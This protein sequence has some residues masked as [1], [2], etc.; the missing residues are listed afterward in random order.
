MSTLVASAPP[1]PALTD[2]QRDFVRAV[3]DFCER[4]CSGERLRE[5]TDGYE[6]FHSPELARRMAALGW[7]GLTI[8]EEYGGAGASVSDA[9][10]FLEEIGRAQ[11]PVRGCA[12]ALIVA[13]GIRRDGSESQKE[14]LLNRVAA[15]GQLSGAVSEPEAGSDVAALRTAARRDGDA[16][17][18]N[19]TKTWCSFAHHAS[20]V[21]VLCRTREGSTGHEGLSSIVVPADAPGLA[22]SPISTLGGHDVNELHFADC[23]VPADAL[24]GTEGEGWTQVMAGFN[25]E[26]VLLGALALGLAQRAFDD[27]LA[28]VKERRQFG[29]PVG[30]FQSMQHRFA[31]LATALE[32]ARL[33]VRQVARLVDEQPDRLLPREASMVK[34]A[35]TELAK[36]CALEGVQAMGACGYATEYPMERHLRT[37]VA[38]TIFG[39]TSEIQKNTIA[40][41]L[42]L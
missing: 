9:A 31:D 32:Q 42:G 29:R 21:M 35:T 15:G 13:E 19:G 23:T 38:T 37:A 20:H 12:V 11:A 10:L 6:D 8:P 33:L 26:R 30:S 14:D 28:F 25:Y 18:I 5:L 27:A 39:G 22:I 4:E 17:V 16:W 7:Y 1:D 24:L 3:R 36:R 34:L 40:K 2:E 41:T